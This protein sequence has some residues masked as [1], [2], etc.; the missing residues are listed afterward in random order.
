MRALPSRLEKTYT[1]YECSQIL[2]ISVVAVR[3]WI[4]RK[5]LPAHK[6]KKI[7]VVRADD[8]RDFQLKL[9]KS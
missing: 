1:V 4:K 3:R 7:W 6:I 5:E 9:K 2:G 8:L